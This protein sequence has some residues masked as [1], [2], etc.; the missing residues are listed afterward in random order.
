[1][2]LILLRNFFNLLLKMKSTSLK[3][4]LFTALVLLSVGC[5]IYVN[6]TSLDRT[7]QVEGTASTVESAEKVEHNAKM[8]DLTLI[9]SAITLIQTFLPAK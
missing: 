1:M 9:K 4:A 6:T 5:F 7:L 3:S 8:P 2:F